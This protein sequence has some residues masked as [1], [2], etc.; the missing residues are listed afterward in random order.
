MGFGHE[1]ET[2]RRCD[3]FQFVTLDGTAN[4]A[5]SDAI[6]KERRPVVMVDC[7]PFSYPTFTIFDLHNFA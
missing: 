3:N 2:L 5:N 1:A 4:D 6:T 7:R